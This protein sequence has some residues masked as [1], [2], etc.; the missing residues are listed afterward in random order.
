MP[1]PG[2]ELRV[3]VRDNRLWHTVKTNDVMYIIPCKFIH[4][5]SDSDWN[6]V[7]LVGESTY[8]YIWVIISLAN[9]EW[10][11]EVHSYGLPR[12]ARDWQAVKQARF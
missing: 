5:C 1:E 7:A 4:L 12:T 8:D 9:R 3:S 11:D 2:G 6:E 10:A